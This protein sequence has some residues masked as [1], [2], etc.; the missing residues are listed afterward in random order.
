MSSDEMLSGDKIPTKKK[1]PTYT[2]FLVHSARSG[3]LMGKFTVQTSDSSDADNENDTEGEQCAS[4]GLT[5]GPLTKQIL[6][7]SMTTPISS[8]MPLSHSQKDCPSNNIRKH[9]VI[10]SKRFTVTGTNKSH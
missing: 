4:K 1:Y 7:K 8:K 2:E 10:I 3:P 6:T 9:G 5:D